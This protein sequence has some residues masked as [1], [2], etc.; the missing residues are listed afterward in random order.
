M[1]SIEHIPI[2]PSK[3]QNSSVFANKGDA[4]LDDMHNK[5]L[6]LKKLSFPRGGG[7]VWVQGGLHFRVS[8]TLGTYIDKAQVTLRDLRNK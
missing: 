1:V 2:F 5:Y 4:E 3:P 7:V 8:G 6:E